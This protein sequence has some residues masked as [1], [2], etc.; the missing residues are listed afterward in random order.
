MFGGEGDECRAEPDAQ[1]LERHLELLQAEYNPAAE[2]GIIC[3]QK[4]A[5]TCRRCA[6]ARVV[7]YRSMQRSCLLRGY[8][9]RMIKLQQLH[10]T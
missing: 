10:L 6:K 2:L 7:A 9:D 8:G 1:E 3:L 5:H 4:L